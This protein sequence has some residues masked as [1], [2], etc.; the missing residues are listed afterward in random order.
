M[1]V[2]VLPGDNVGMRRFD[3]AVFDFGGVMTEPIFRRPRTEDAGAR[4]TSFF[5]TETLSVYAEPT[6]DHDLH[7][8]EIG[9]MSEADFVQRLLAR[10]VAAGNAPI[11]VEDARSALFGKG[12]VACTAMVDAVAEVRA[13]GYRTALLTNNVREWEAD[14]RGLVP[15]DDLF[16]VVVDSSVVG[17]RKPDL[18]IYRLC[19]RQLEVDP[20][21]CLFVDD[22]RC[23]VEAATEL[24]MEVLHCTDPVAAAAEVRALLLEPEA[25]GRPA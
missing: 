17:L 8:L 21:R 15:V 3:A 9:R 10:F 7:L 13:A 1:F 19:C 11:T 2:P 25:A 4:L 16:D 20:G 23:N 12:L 14:W 22:L 24:G 6:G 5:I 18:E